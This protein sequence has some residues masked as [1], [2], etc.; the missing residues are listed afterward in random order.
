M[1][2]IVA[3]IIFISGIIFLNYYT[4]Q[5]SDTSDQNVSGVSKVSE[6][7]T[8]TVA[9][10]S[11]INLEKEFDQFDKDQIVLLKRVKSFGEKHGYPY[12]FP[13]IVWKES[14]AGLF[15]VNKRGGAYGPFQNRLKTVL[16]RYKQENLDK[17]SSHYEK[18]KG[19]LKEKLLKDF[20]FAANEALKEIK[21]WERVHTKKGNTPIN[22]YI[23]R[24]YFGGYSYNNEA[25]KKY[26]DDV[27][28][29]AQYLKEINI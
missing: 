26:A 17:T 24:S 15:M 20:N 25:A 14:S 10:S 18:M 16:S 1:K 4:S 3:V 9:K 6:N 23:L 13:A 11:H 21:F 19:V 12:I 7:E 28:H 29:K 27:L 5:K 2:K 22:M 8:K